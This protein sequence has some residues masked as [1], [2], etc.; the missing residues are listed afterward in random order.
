MNVAFVMDGKMVVPQTSDTVL[1]G[2][3]R[4]SAVQLMRHHGVEVEE[5]KVTVQE[6]IDA[7]AAGRLTKRLALVPLRPYRPFARWVCP[8]V[9]GICLRCRHGRSLPKSKHCWMACVMGQPK[10]PLAGTFQSDFS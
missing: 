3:T 7:S 5:R 9:I 2:I 8:M 4:A 1:A 10:T 6:L